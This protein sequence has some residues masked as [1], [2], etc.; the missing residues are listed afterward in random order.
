VMDR[1]YGGI[2]RWLLHDYNQGVSDSDLTAFVGHSRW[3]F[4]GKSA[5]EYAKSIVKRLIPNS[6]HSAL[7][8]TRSFA[9]SGWRIFRNDPQHH[10]TCIR[11]LRRQIESI[12]TAT[13]KKNWLNYYNDWFPT[14]SP[15]S[16]W[17]AKHYSVFQVLSDIR[18]ISVL[19]IASNRGWYSQLAAITGSK[20]VAFDTDEA[21]I[22]QLYCDAKEKNLSI[23]PLIMDFRSPSP[24]YGLCNQ[25]L[26]PATDRL[27]CEM[28]FALALVHHLVFKQNLNFDQIVDALSV[29]SKQWLLVEFIPTEDIRVRDWWSE[30]YSCDW[31]SEKY[32]WYT[33][34]NFVAAVKKRFRDIRVLPSYPEPRVLILGKKT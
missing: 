29:F 19:D 13:A 11:G 21:C 20:V 15:S 31:W 6:Y 28:V 10:L 5:G 16:D 27:R 17:T 33:L 34:D 24:G 1:G 12:D 30:K 26:A 9:A 25:S 14:F 2:A 32:S 3:L 8:K 22:T 23:L 4:K 18:P 7:K